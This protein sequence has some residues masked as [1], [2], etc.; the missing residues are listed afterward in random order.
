MAFDM[1]LSAFYSHIKL[2]IIK[3][4]IIVPEIYENL[5]KIFYIISCINV[6]TTPTKMNVAKFYLDF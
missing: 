4:E 3:T 1:Y 5:H 6:P 2:H